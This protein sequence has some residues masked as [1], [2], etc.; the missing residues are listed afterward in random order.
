LNGK[1]LRAAVYKATAVATNADGSSAP[2]VFYFKIT[3][4]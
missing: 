4:R 3:K 1:G 2:A